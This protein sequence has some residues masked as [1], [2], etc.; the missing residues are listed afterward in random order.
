[1]K[2]RSV[3][4]PAL[5]FFLNAEQGERFC[6]Y[7]H[8]NSAKE[9]LGAFIYIHPFAEEMNKSRRM[10]AM[11]SRALSDMGYAVLQLDLFGCGDSSGEFADARWETWIADLAAAEKWLSERTSA[12]IS[13]W[14]LRLGALLA[15]DYARRTPGKI[16]GVILWQPIVNT[17][18][19]LT[20]FLR[21][22]LANEISA[23]HNK[24]NS[25]TKS[26]LNDL[27]MGK[28]IEIAGYELAPALAFAINNLRSIELAVKNCPVHWFE[29]VSESPLTLPP[30]AENLRHSWRQQGSDVRVHLV[31]GVPFWSTPEISVCPGLLAAM[32]YHLSQEEI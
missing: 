20:Q 13:L 17:V 22:R 16:D 8:P 1:M 7:H 4:L 2:N 9:C 6:I 25:G 3:K 26:L 32:A 30:A 21:L 11:Q 14:G 19:Y 23:N 24:M 12:G 10:V 18:T 5:P 15:L 31:P 28:I 29:I 27:A